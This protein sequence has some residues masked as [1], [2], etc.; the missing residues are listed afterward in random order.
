MSE[1]LAALIKDCRER[2][3]DFA[4]KPNIMDLYQRCYFSEHWKWILNCHNVCSESIAIFFL[5]LI[6]IWDI[7]DAASLFQCRRFAGWFWRRN[8]RRGRWGDHIFVVDAQTNPN[9]FSGD[10]IKV[11]KDEGENE[12][13]QGVSESLH[14]DLLGEAETKGLWKLPQPSYSLPAFHQQAL[15]M[16]YLMNPYGALAAAGG[17]SPFLPIGSPPLQVGFLM[18]IDKLR[19]PSYQ[20]QI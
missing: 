12:E 15:S 16:G 1:V 14:A 2:S 8:S 19:N 5:V 6:D 10:E 18:F 7:K 17:L 13:E 9:N 3:K 20:D 4:D 11:F